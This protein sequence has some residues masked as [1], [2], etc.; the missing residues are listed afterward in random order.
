MNR[1]TPAGLYELLPAVIRMRDAEEGEPLRALVDIL[2]REGAVVEES[3]AQLLDDQF[4]ETCAPWVVPYLGALIGYRPLHAIDALA[5]S[6]RADAANTIARR[7]RKGT[8]A[9]L[10]QLARDVTG[11]PARAVEYFQTTAC[12]QHVNVPRPTHA[13]APD[14]RNPLPLEALGTAFETLSRS[15]DMRAITRGPGRRGLGGRHNFP[16]IGIHLWRLQA[17][18]HSD[19]PAAR[20][21]T[22]RFLFDPLGAPR[23]LFT[24]PV[25]EDTIATLATP[26]NVPGPISRRA[27]DA[28]LTGYYGRDADGALRSFEIAL[29][30]TA[31]PPTRITVCDLSDDGAGWNHSPHVAQPGDPP[32]NGP[33]R[34]DPVLGR[35]AFPDAVPGEVRASFHLAA[36]TDIGGGE[37]NRAAALAPPTAARPLRRFPD[38]A[39]AD[40]QAAIDSLPATGGIVE[41]ITNDTIDATPAIT[42]AP[43]AAVELRAAD[44]TRPVLRLSGDLEV[45]GGTDARLSIDGLVI[46]GGALRILP[47]GGTS[48]GAVSLRHVTLVPGL[49]LDAAG[50]PATPGAPSLIVAA[51]GVTLTLERSITGPLRLQDT[52]T[53]TLR[54]TIV[55]A[56]EAEAIDSPAGLAI[57]GLADE[58]AASVT[59]LAST[60]IGRIRAR[61]LPLVSDAILFSRA[62]AAGEPPVRSLRRQDGCLRFSFVPQGSVTPRRHRCQPQLAIDRALAERTKALGAPPGPAERTLIAARTARALLPSFTAQRYGAP[63]YGQLRAATPPEIRTGASDE[64]EMGALHHLYQPQREANLAIRLE[65]YLRFGLEAGVFFES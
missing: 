61:T 42:L 53:A 14:L 6:P 57:A 31:I 21:D 45:T 24:A 37:Y 54:D 8:A 35:I 28:D 56:A 43:G 27:L 2:A 9:V 49:A 15:A 17:T 23:Q 58:P 13:L 55:D 32:A 11:W 33:V 63:A 3:I 59:I 12:C 25:A 38:A 36:P 22:R 46:I 60:I 1:I 51:A 5:F 48:P 16:N 39:F 41:I 50:A 20:V 4:I 7:R 18:R 29:D 26:L 65:E 34:V 47:G 62:S 52:T 64:S 30:G 40:L 10:E 44:E 19:V